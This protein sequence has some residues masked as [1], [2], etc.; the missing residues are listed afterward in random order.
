MLR[1]NEKNRILW[2]VTATLAVNLALLVLLCSVTGNAAYSCLGC[3]G[4]RVAVIQRSLRREGLYGGEISGI[5]D[6]SLRK[7]IK[8]FQQKHGLYETGEADSKTAALLGIS[9]KSGQCFHIETELLARYLQVKFPSTRFPEL[10]NEARQIT[11]T[12]PSLA[13]L[14]RREEDILKL[15][16][17]AEPSSEAYEAACEAVF[18]K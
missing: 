6:L 10:L 12:V 3:T 8:E 11:D 1:T 4:E 17:D 9:S 18:E 2:R 13:A 14:L 15:I 5:Y 7:G 16:L